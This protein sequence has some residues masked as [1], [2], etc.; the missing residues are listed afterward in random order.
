MADMGYFY[1][2][3]SVEKRKEGGWE[4]VQQLQSASSPHAA[5][6]TTCFPEYSKRCTSYL[7]ILKFQEFVKN[8]H[9]FVSDKQWKIVKYLMNREMVS[10]ALYNTPVDDYNDFFDE[11]KEQLSDSEK[12]EL[13]KYKSKLS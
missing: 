13:K 12:E 1:M 6:S 3:R 2:L 10:W 11:S 9:N 4:Y 5:P 8:V 7:D